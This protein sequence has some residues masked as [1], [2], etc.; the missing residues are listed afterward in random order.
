V[1]DKIYGPDEMLY[2]KFIETG[3]TPNLE[4]E[5]LL[6]RHALHSAALECEGV[7]WESP[8][9]PDLAAFCNDGPPVAVTRFTATERRRSH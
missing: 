7:R 5:L 9:P 4:Q 2:L 3:W 6:P 1:G 8:L